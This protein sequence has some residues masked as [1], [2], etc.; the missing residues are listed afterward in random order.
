MLDVFLA[1]PNGRL[2][3]VYA[4]VG[5]SGLASY[6]G[7]GA[8]LLAVRVTNRLTLG[9]ELDV[10]RQPQI[11]LERGVFDPPMRVGVNVGGFIDVR[12]TNELSLTGKLAAKTDGYV[13]GQPIGG[14]PYGYL[15]MSLAWP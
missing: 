6:Y 2:L 4:R 9:G 3:D 12:L 5:T 7:A 14:G 8:R 13:M 11:L 10:W 15:G 1:D